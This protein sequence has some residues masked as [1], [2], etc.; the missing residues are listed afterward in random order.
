MGSTLFRRAALAD[1]GFTRAGADGC[2]DFDLLV[3]LALAG[4]QGYFIPELLME[5]RFHGGQTSVR[6]AIH[7]LGAKSFCL[8]SY[9]FDDPELERERVRRLAVL[10]DSLGLRLIETGETRRGRELLQQAAPVLG[11]SR[12]S[13]L[14]FLLSY[15][16]ATPREIAFESFRALRPKD[17]TERVR[18]IG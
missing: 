18:S 6:Q 4:K 11:R 3:R 14:G 16:P 15:L 17:Y 5:Y 1:V 10:R 2:E 7:F 8:E 12:R 13:L 9:R